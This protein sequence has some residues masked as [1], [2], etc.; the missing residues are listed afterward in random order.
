[1]ASHWTVERKGLGSLG[2]EKKERQ[3]EK[4]SGGESREERGI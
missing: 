4:G 2:V 3:P 1:M